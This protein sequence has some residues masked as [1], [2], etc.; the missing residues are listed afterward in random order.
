MHSFYNSFYKSVRKV[1]GLGKHFLHEPYFSQE[2][3]KFVTRTIKDKFV[4]S[5]GKDTKKFEQE[6]INFTKSKYCIATTSGTAAIQIALLAS[7]VKPNDEVLVP[8]LTF[9]G[10]ANA[11]SHC[12]AIPHFVDSNIDNFGLDVD[13]LEN[14]LKK[15][16]IIKKKYLINKKTKRKVKAIIPVHIFGHAC[17]IEAINNLAKSYNL[18]VVEDAAEGVGSF[19]NNKHLG[20]FSSFG[21]F[22]FIHTHKFFYRK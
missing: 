13:K 22:S 16:F 3:I 7:D 9:V 6:I 19:H 10:T 14:Y 11:V 4:S 20:T 12:G 21:C 5:A 18:K 17:S 15:N 2:E 8:A 1:T